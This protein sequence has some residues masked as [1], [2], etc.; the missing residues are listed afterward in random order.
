MEKYW[1]KIMDSIYQYPTFARSVVPLLL[2]GYK[3]RSFS[4][5]VMNDLKAIVL[6]LLPEVSITFIERRLLILGSVTNSYRF[7]KDNVFESS[8]F[9]ISNETHRIGFINMYLKM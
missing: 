4:V 6:K 2:N 3:N 5:D 7:T 1:F 8:D 9:N